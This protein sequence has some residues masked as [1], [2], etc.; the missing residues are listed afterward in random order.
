MTPA[1]PVL[2]TAG[3]QLTPLAATDRRDLLAHLGDSATVE[4]MDIEALVDLAGAEVIIA[5]AAGLLASGHGVRW[6][7]RDRSGAFVGTARFNALVRER[8]SRGELAYDIVRP[9]WRQGVMA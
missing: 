5:W 6:A 2:E 1:I 4:H 7:I 3:F 8:A 9:R